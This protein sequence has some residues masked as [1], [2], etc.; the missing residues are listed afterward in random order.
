M[1]AEIRGEEGVIH[2]QQMWHVM[3]PRREDLPVI[4]DLLAGFLRKGYELAEIT[5][6]IEELAKAGLW[7]PEM[8]EWP[9][10][11]VLAN[12]RQGALL[13]TAAA[14]AGEAYRTQA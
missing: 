6:A 7:P 5:M 1:E 2:L 9:L 4:F 13:T 10:E 14:A 8:A 12:V 11:S 3:W